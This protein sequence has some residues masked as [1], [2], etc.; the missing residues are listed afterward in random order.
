MIK[1]IYKEKKEEADKMIISLFDKT[2]AVDG[3][4][5]NKACEEVAHHFGI[6]S[7]QVLYLIKER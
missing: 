6:S 3:M 1:S 5:K 2:M 7:R 4:T